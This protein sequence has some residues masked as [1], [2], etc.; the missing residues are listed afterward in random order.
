MNILKLMEERHS[1]RQYKDMPIESEKREILDG[2]AAELSAKSGLNIKIVYDEPA[3]FNSSLARYGNFRNV[4]NYI[5]IFG[6]KDMDEKVGYYG[7]ELV[8]K[9]QELGLNTCWVVLT[10][11]RKSVK[12]LSNDLKLYGV[13][14]LGY[15]ETQGVPHKSKPTEKLV[16]IKGEVPEN[17]DIGVK[18]AILAP[19]ATN[20]QKF[21]II[22]ENG[23]VKIVK[24]GI[25]FYTDLDLGIIKYPFEKASGIK[26]FNER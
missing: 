24:S 6:K 23:A 18:A 1:V 17:F 21:K 15:G 2:L 22:C 19:T 12:A 9:A 26:V 25:G 11:N 10:F 14:A 3:G 7:E 13:I 4:N 5:A 20:Q 16:E 8:L